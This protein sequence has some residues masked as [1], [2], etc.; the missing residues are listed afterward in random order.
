M[1]SRPECDVAFNFIGYRNFHHVP[2][3]ELT[4]KLQTATKIVNAVHDSQTRSAFNHL[5][6]NARRC[7]SIC[8]DNDSPPEC[9]NKINRYF[10]RVESIE[11]CNKNPYQCL[12]LLRAEPEIDSIILEPINPKSDFIQTLQQNDHTIYNWTQ[13]VNVFPPILDLLQIPTDFRTRQPLNHRHLHYL[14]DNDNFNT[15]NE[16]LSEG[17]SLISPPSHIPHISNSGRPCQTPC[18]YDYWNNW[19]IKRYGCWI[20]RENRVNDWCN[21]NQ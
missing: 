1:T 11:F 5:L 17:F 16:M 6:T 13:L 21:P 8:N 10:N 18:S 14:L 7:N 20:N 19:P 4:P 3:R 2:D 9:Q 15:I 12:Y